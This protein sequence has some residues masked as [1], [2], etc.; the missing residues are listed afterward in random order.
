MNPK[1]CKQIVRKALAQ[2]ESKTGSAPFNGPNIL[3]A[4]DLDG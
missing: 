2:V 4:T 3:P 1:E